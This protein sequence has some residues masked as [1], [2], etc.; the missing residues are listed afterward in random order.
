MVGL[1]R[2][3]SHITL[4]FFIPNVL[5]PEAAEFI[6]EVIFCPDG[7]DAEAMGTWGAFCGWE[8]QWGFV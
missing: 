2:W 8:E 6:G 5:R 7:G 4:P 3:A 1:W